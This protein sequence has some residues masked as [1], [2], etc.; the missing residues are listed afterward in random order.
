M[1]LCTP[2]PAG[3]EPQAREA[4]RAWNGVHY[5]Y[6]LQSIH[7]GRWGIPVQ[8]LAKRMSQLD[9][10]PGKTRYGVQRGDLRTRVRDHLERPVPTRTSQV[11]PAPRRRLGTGSTRPRRPQR[12]IGYEACLSEGDAKQREL[13]TLKSGLRYLTAKTGGWQG[14]QGLVK[15]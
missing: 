10:V 11:R 9:P 3:L 2:F 6:L 4:I 5:T 14:L 12:F 13:Q 7:D 15:S 1:S 8:P